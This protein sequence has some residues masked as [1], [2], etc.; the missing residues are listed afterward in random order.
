M[1][2]SR[3]EALRELDALATVEHALLVEYLRVSCVLGDGD[4]T[5][6]PNPRVAAA[7]GDAFDLAVSA[8]KQLHRINTALTLAG[9]P[10]QVGR[11]AAIRTEAGVELAFGPLSRADLDRLVAREEDLARAV[12][13]RTERLRPTVEGPDAV[14]ADELLFAVSGVV[15][16]GT[17][18]AGA[19]DRLK[20][21]LHDVPP[22]VYLRV[23]R[24]EPADDA[25]RAVLDLADRHYHLV[26]ANVRAAF[27]YDD[28]FGGSLLQRALSTM[29]VMNAVDGL[30]TARGL[31]PAFTAPPG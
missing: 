12:D 2:L 6:P 25:E 4:G 22:A 13:A 20:G 7:S 28:A 24:Q 8:M 14:F 26:V 17:G 27:A 11:A 23:T 29:D 30:L 10:P 31:L 16:V 15:D 9:W 5:A 19:L 3:D 18:H 21:H 1:A